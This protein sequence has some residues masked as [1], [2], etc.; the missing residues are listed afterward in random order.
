ME[1]IEFKGSKEIIVF[2]KPFPTIIIAILI[3]LI[4]I[5][6]SN[7]KFDEEAFPPTRRLA[8]IQHQKIKNQI[9]LLHEAINEEFKELRAEFE[10]IDS[11][12]RNKNTD[13]I[14]WEIS[15]RKIVMR[16]KRIIEFE[17]EIVI[18]SNKLERDAN[19]YEK[20]QELDKK[21]AEITNFQN[22]QKK[23]SNEPS[24]YNVRPK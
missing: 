13:C 19:Y 1:K 15:F 10:K 9:N 17:R 8:A 7:Y 3:F 24:Y 14:D 18:F 21:L 22:Q 12:I 23:K 6:L 16:E 20:I 5:S 4:C 2:R 11:L